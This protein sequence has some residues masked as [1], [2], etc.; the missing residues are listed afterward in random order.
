MNRLMLILI[1]VN[2]IT[3]DLISAWKKV[4]KGGMIG[5]DDLTQNLWQHGPQHE[6]TLVFPYAL[7]F[8]EA[9]K[10]TIFLLPFNQFL[11]FKN[12]DKYEFVDYTG[13]Y[14]FFGLKKLIPKER[15]LK[16]A[17]IDRILKC[18]RG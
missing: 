17:L 4:K 13:T 3:I 8:A 7:Y 18:F 15:T 1:L 10:S 11:I 2:G 5:G 14:Q 16:Q 6:P 12:E 9:M